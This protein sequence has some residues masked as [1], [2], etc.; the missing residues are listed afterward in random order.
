MK[1]AWGCVERVAGMGG[2]LCRPS[3]A[4][5]GDGD[6][7]DGHGDDENGDNEEDD[8]E[9]GKRGVESWSKP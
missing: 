6:N 3:A 4:K 1:R 7:D 2:E 8:N 9:G 5:K